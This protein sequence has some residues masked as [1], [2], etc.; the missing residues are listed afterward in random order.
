ME[1][2]QTPTENVG[3]TEVQS[4]PTSINIIPFV[5]NIPIQSIPQMPPLGPA[6]AQLP[7]LGPAPAQLPPLVHPPIPTPQFPPLVYPPVPIPQSVVNTNAINQEQVIPIQTQ[8]ETLSLNTPLEPIPQQSVGN[9]SQFSSELNTTQELVDGNPIDPDAAVNPT[10]E[11]G[12]RG[13]YLSSILI[14][15]YI[16][17][18]N[19]ITEYHTSKYVDTKRY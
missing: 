19:R 6:P 12:K 15:K 17:I 4:L 13:M 11:E 16:Y 2:Q 3:S 14:N 18:I 5:P 9:D 10:G 8:F 1:Q 7:P